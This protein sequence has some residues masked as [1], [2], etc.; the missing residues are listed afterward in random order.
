MLESLWQRHLT[1]PRCRRIYDVHPPKGVH[2]AQASSVK[3]GGAGLGHVAHVAVDFCRAGSY[4]VIVVLAK[5]V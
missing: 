4:N 5:R 3:A 2:Y 1:Q